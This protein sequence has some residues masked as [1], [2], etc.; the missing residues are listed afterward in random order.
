MP[1]THADL[2]AAHDALRRNLDNLRSAQ[3]AAARLHPAAPTVGDDRLAAQVV[4]LEAR[5]TRFAEVLAARPA[6]VVVADA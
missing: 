1:L 3:R 6:T 5:V 4:E 2:I